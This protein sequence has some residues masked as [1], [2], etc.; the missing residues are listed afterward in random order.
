MTQEQIMQQNVISR[1]S[2][3]QFPDE[4]DPAN[5]LARQK[6]PAD[7]KT[8]LRSCLSPDARRRPDPLTCMES[9]AFFRDY[10]NKSSRRAPRPPQ[11]QSMQPPQVP[12]PR[13]LHVQHAPP[14]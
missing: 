14:S 1:F 3:V 12:V 11:S 2:E 9:E 13:H 10:L 8:F 5:C 7:V 4:R 6:V